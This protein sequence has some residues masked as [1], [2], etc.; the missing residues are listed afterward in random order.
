MAFAAAVS[1]VGTPLLQL[2]AAST[3]MVANPLT[4][5]IIAGAV[6]A[7]GKIT[8]YGFGRSTRSLGDDGRIPEKVRLF[9]DRNMATS[10]FTFSLTP[11]PMID[12][13]G[14]AAGRAGYPLSRFL[15]LAAAG[16]VLQS[17]AVVYAALWGIEFVA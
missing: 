10:I 12:V 1:L 14:I 9:V 6:G 8:V 4:V 16:K 5:A 17:I 3:V 15:A 11:S 2:G 13:I 7:L